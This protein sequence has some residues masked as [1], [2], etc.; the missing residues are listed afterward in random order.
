VF[1]A[2]NYSAAKMRKNEV[3]QNISNIMTRNGM[4]RKQS[5][6]KSYVGI[7]IDMALARGKISN[8]LVAQRFEIDEGTIR[9]WRK[10]YNDFNRVF[11][12]AEEMLMEKINGVATKSLSVRK[13]KSISRG[14]KGLTTT[15]ED[16]LPTH[17]DVAVFA[18][19]LGMGTS[20]YGDEQA[21][22]DDRRD[23]VRK[24]LKSKVAGEL[25]LA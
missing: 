1:F 20:I 15:V 11:T 7:V 21:R 3:E 23:Y 6:K 22:V 14:P 18:K 17:S 25:A 9:N 10:E 24:T 4:T 2:K 19:H 13:R 16:V 8:R 5:F 12:E